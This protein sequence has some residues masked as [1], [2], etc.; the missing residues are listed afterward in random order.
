[1]RLIVAKCGGFC[2]G[3]KAA[4][5]KTEEAAGNNTYTYGELIHNE[6]VLA[7][8]AAK[9]VRAVERISDIPPGEATVVIRSHGAGRAVYDEIKVRGF[10]VV[11]ATCPFVKK[12]HSIVS[13][14]SGKG[15]RIFIIG[16]EDH[17]EVKG[18]A[19]WC[20]G[21]ATVI[22]EN[23]DFSGE[24]REQKA[25]FVAQ[26][27]FSTEKYGEIIKKIRKH[28][29]KTVEIFD[30]ICYTTISRQNEARR[31]SRVCD[32]VLVVGSG[33]SSNT[34]KLVALAGSPTCAAYL[35]GGRD[36]LTKINFGTEDTVGIIAGAS[37]PEELITEVKGYMSEKFAVVEN[38]EFLAAVENGPVSLKEGKRVK[39]KV[40]SADETGIQLNI[41]GKKDGFIPKEEVNC[42]GS[43]DPAEFTEG[44]ELEVRIGKSDSDN[45]RILLSKKAVDEI[46]EADKIIETIRNGETFEVTVQKAVE[47]GLV[48]KLGTYS[49]FIPASQVE[50]RFVRDLKKYEGKKLVVTALEIDD[51]KRKIVASHR[52]V[53]EAERKEREEVFWANVV[54]NMIVSG[55]VKRITSFG[56]FVSVDGFDCLAH[57]GD[58]SWT[59][60]KTVDEV[61]TVGKT[62]EF[63]V[64]TADREKNRV[65]LGYKQLQ[66]HPFVA[67][68]EKHPVGSVV[69]GKVVSVVQFGVFVEIE[70]H[71]EGLVHVSEVAHT[72][73]KN[74]S[75]VVKVGDEVE[76]KI[77]GYD[78]NNRKINLSIKACLPDEPKPERR[79]DSAEGERK[80][81]RGKAVKGETE[82][83]EEGEKE[84]NEDTTHNPFADLLKDLDVK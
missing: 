34:A 33:L 15:Y 82:Q 3:V 52:K 62:Y 20:D 8:L 44:M 70:P 31:L 37:A 54:P 74:I 23:Y 58:L 66:P 57:I 38:E 59:H 45:S 56:A 29:F 65:L 75:D 72:F 13:D 25:C 5:K 41:G 81:R 22:D 27:T 30:T 84:W 51:N 42:D 4:V 10:T 80:P 7:S 24:D 35:V 60:I 36:D 64:L 48:A 53:V 39:G 14:Y 61:L 47:K 28:A 11:D 18:I 69:T 50:E 67:C 17:P 16:S 32:K 79:E 40:I 26:T 21:G 43:Y 71:I 19:G 55:E 76:V 2:F 12:I 6:R 68:M 83:A 77:L 1:M 9:G 63:V 78:E 46:K 73:V 49:V